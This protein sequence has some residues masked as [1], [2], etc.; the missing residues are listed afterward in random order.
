VAGSS[1][2]RR[3]TRRPANRTPP[4]QRQRPTGALK[5]TR[6]T[7]PA[8]PRSAARAR[9]E[10]FSAP[11]L[12]RLHRMPK[13]VVPLLMVALL[14]VALFVGGFAGVACLAALFLMLGWLTALSWPVTT[15]RGRTS[16]VVVLVLIAG[17]AVSEALGLR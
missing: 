4:R 15:T 1:S 10:R 6:S 12:L 8:A 7:P 3:N 5:E 17:F 16:R 11:V 9:L 2:A 14:A 13:P